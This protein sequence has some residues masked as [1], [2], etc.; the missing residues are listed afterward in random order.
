MKEQHKKEEDFHDEW[1]GITDINKIDVLH[2]NEAHTAPE[3]RYIHRYLGNLK[4]KNVLDVGCG[5]GEASVYFALNGARVTSLDLSSGMLKATSSLAQKY[6]VEVETHL[7]TAESI[8]LSSDQ[9]FDIIYA[10]NLL[11]H[12]DIESVLKQFKKHLVDGGLLVTWDPLQYNPAINFYRRRAMEVRTED[13]HPL[14]WSDLKLFD[15]YFSNVTRKYFWLS[16]LVIFIYMALIERRDPNKERY[17]KIVINESNRWKWF[18]KP[19]EFLDKLILMLI[20]PLRL[21]CWNVVVISKK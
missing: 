16:T 6:R 18:Y 2:V 14:T 9:N 8:N 13:E 15:K 10:G 12:V 7:A 3:M 1:A 19:F 20:P 17:W 5:L 11:H 21:M 4:G